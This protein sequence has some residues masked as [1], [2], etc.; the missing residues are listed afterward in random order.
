MDSGI[1]V[2]SQAPR[3]IVKLNETLINQIAAGE[4]VER[5]AS[6]LKELVENSLDAG[7]RR[8]EIVLKEGGMEELTVIDNGHGMEADDLILSVERHATSKISKA[9][10]LEAIGT[11]GFR[12]EA[13]SSISSVSEIE[14]KSRT[15][16]GSQGNQLVMRYGS[17]IDDLKPVGVAVGTTITVKNLFQKIPA[18]QKFLRSAG[19]EFSHCAR[20]IKE[21]ALGN[22]QV[23]FYLHHQ[24][25]LVHS[26]APG[27]RADRLDSILRWE[28]KPLRVS[29]QADGVTVDAF[30]SPPHLLQD[31]GELL[32]F[33]NGR[34]VRNKSLTAAIRNTFLSTLGSHHEPS[35]VVFLEIRPDWVDVNVHPQKLEVRVLRQEAIYQWL[36]ASVRKALAQNPGV[37]EFAPSPAELKVTEPTLPFAAPSRSQYSFFAPPPTTAP[38]LTEGLRYLGQFKASYLVCEDSEGLVLFDQ[39][40]LHE[41]LFFEKL[42]AQHHTGFKIQA[43]LVPKILHLARELEPLLAE[44]KG[45]LLEMGFEIEAFGDGDIAVKTRPDILPENEIE[46][47]LNEVLQAILRQEPAKKEPFSPVRSILATIACHSVVR[48]NQSLSDL[49]AHELLQGL[50]KLEEGWTCPH[51]RP[52]LF[53]IRFQTIE[54]YFERK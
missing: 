17:L 15:A 49:Q 43:L 16:S 24:G 26:Y 11:F 41:K 35:G 34:S 40:A 27:T 42:E 23:G 4:V 6:A 30:L 50:G 1:P 52:V 14:I 3:K 18:R 54:K 32:L 53:R 9:S 45:N 20:V 29:E 28:W 47:V 33:I 38:L 21:M 39:H 10:D 7:A 44:Q 25:R 46:R 36:T 51:G 31:R 19:T 8:I 2:P 12:G 22:P 37:R 48:S 13:L 5:P